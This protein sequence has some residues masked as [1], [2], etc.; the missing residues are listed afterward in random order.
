MCVVGKTGIG[1]TWAVRDALGSFI[2]ITPD[3]LK[4]KQDTIDF[5]N[6]IRGTDMSVI[7]DEYECAVGLIGLK[8]ITEIPTSGM[9]IVISQIPVKFDFEIVIYNF[10]I[11]T[12]ENIKRIVPNASDQIIDAADGD[13]Q[14]VIQATNFKSDFKDDFHG[15]R[16][17]LGSLV[18]RTSDTDPC[19][20]IG[21]PLIEPGNMA[22]ILN[23]N[24]LDS[25]TVKYENVTEMFSQADIV[26]VLI[27]A[28][29][30][31]LLPYFNFWGC[32][33]P[34]IEIGHTLGSNLKPG[35]SWTKYQNMCMRR[36]KIRA[37]YE[38]V[39]QTKQDLDGILLIMDY[40]EKEQPK[41]IELMREYG[42]LR[43]DIDVLNHLSPLRKLKAKTVCQIKKC[44]S[45]PP[46]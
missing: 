18:S 27:Y 40:I 1:K 4:S 6:K 26:D 12:H 32:I 19:K 34:S 44:V 13:I 16:E 31:E 28:G 10:P 2:E 7:L 42:F 5:L 14:W 11:P 43:E 35:S 41:S 24:Y 9:F 30:W 8:E 20:F 33:L 23:A 25:P 17:F 21:Y 39:P 3:I 45:A 38:R 37:M 15:P 22:S 36:K 29:G 46:P